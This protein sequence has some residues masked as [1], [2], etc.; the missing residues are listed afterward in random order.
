MELS[1]LANAAAAAL[2]PLLAKG[3]GKFAEEFGKDAYNKAKVGLDA[4]RS[5]LT[6]KPGAEKALTACE[7]AD[8]KGTV[9]LAG[10]VQAE[11]AANPVFAGELIP[12]IQEL[13]VFMLAASVSRPGGDV[14]NIEAK[15]LGVAGPQGQATFHLGD[16]ALK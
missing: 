15:I 11:L 12:L 3:A 4:L 6:G 16:D 8:P 13:A 9:Q 14:Y 10:V 5:R 2:S 1:L 7:R